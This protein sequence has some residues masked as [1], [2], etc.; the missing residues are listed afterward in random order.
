MFQI[1]KFDFRTVGN[2]LERLRAE[3]L[4]SFQR[5]TFYR[6]ERKF[7]FPQWDKE[8]GEWRRYSLKE[9]NFIINF[10]KEKYKITADTESTHFV[11]RFINSF[12]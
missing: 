4:P 8:P 5:V 9:F 7:K 3:G 2:I 6:M 12:K 10:I 11:A 1:R